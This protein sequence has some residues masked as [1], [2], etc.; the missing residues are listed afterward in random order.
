MLAAPTLLK[1]L[2]L[3]MPLE[4]LV[5]RPLKVLSALVPL[6]ALRGHQGTRTTDA[7]E[8]YFLLLEETM[9]TR[10]H[11]TSTGSAVDP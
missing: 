6:E 9:M 10:K 8:E 1:V 4:V 3:L 2:K 11:G 7:T 5:A